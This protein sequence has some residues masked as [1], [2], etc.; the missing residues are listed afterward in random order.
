MF[1]DD[2][3][4]REVVD[5]GRRQRGANTHRG[6]RD[7]AIGLVEG[8]ALRREVA[9]PSPRPHA[10]CRAERGDPQPT[11]QAANRSL[12]GRSHASPDLLDRDGADP[13]FGSDT[14]QSAQAI[15]GTT[16]AQGVDQDGRVEYQSG[17]SADATTVAAALA[18]D[19]RGR[20]RV[21][22]VTGVGQLAEGRLD[23]VPPSL[24]VEAPTHQLCDEGAPATGAD[25]SV[26]LGD[27]AVLQ[28]YV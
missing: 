1:D 23:V 6:G 28:R 12:F 25:P 9:P 17:H 27:Q 24:V 20:V 26:E 8:D 15:G 18:P 5:V 3:G 2:V 10:L 11:E 16:S 19:P 7:Q 21:P 14:P 13:R 4:H 22:V